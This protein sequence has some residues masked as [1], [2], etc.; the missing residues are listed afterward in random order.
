MANI[1]FAQE[2]GL[3]ESIY[4]SSQAPIRAFIEQ[5]AEA[6][7]QNSVWK[8]LFKVQKSNR[9]AEKI[10]SMTAMEGPRPVGEN[11]LA[12]VDGYQEGFSKE[13]HH[14]AW[15]D[16]F[17][18]T[19]VMVDDAQMMDLKK[20]PAAFI[21]AYYRKMEVFAASMFGRAF[22]GAD[23]LTFDGWDF[24]LTTAD[25]VPLF[26]AEH[27]S[28][29]RAGYKQSNQFSNALTADNLGLLETAHQMFTDDDGNILNLAPDTIVIPNV[30]SIKK[31]AFLAVGSEKSPVDSTN[32][33]NYQFGRWNV[34]VWPYLNRFV[35]EGDAP[36]MLLDSRYLDDFDAALW[37]DRTG[38]E[39]NSYIDHS[40]LANV[41]QMY[42][43]FGAGFADWRAFSVGGI[44]DAT[45]LS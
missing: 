20:Q 39:V 41:W 23:K 11:G 13:I 30:Q 15:R 27:K 42:F 4:G 16:Q 36:W 34:I 31:A 32:A 2:P 37:F 8:K 10:T 5:R 21:A 24:P 12:P 38:L 18:I 22:G 33:M 25:D 6:F 1:I 29:T 40:T 28:K 26:S 45:Q 43:R 3:N 14:V 17:A 9:W 19:R 35:D 7:E 44:A